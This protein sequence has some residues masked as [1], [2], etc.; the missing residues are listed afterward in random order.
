MN[1]E[2][3]TV[4]IY[5]RVSTD[6]QKKFGIS[7]DDQKNSLTRYCKENKYKIYDYYIDEGVSAGTISK[8]KEFVRLLKDLDKI[9]IILFT[10]LDRFSRN[11]RDAN[12][13]LVELDK[14]N[15][16]FKAIDEDDIDT[17]TADGRFIFNLKVNLAE[18]ERN[19]DSERI[20][21]VNKYKYHT[22]KTVCSGAKKFG[23]DIKDKR[24]VINE[25]EAIQL[26]ALY[27][28]YI[29][30][31]C[32]SETIK[33]FQLNIKKRSYASVRIYLTD[34]SYIGKYKHTFRKTKETEIIDNFCPPIID[35]EKFYKVQKMLNNNVKKYIEKKNPE[36]G[37]KADYIFSGMLFCKCGKKLS[38]KH[39]KGKHYY[40]CKRA[41]TTICDNKIHISELWL[42][43]YLL[44]NIKELINKELQKYEIANIKS[45]EKQEKKSKKERIK[46]VKNKMEKI[47]N[48][49]LEEMIDED[50]Y[51]KEY[52][53]LKEELNKIE[54]EKEENNDSE[55]D[56]E[57]LKKFLNSDFQTIYNSLSNKEKRELWLSIIEKITFNSKEDFYITLSCTKL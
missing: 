37:N 17:S 15:T 55:I 24:L 36:R 25:N 35:E 47:V 5:C 33:W 18:H 39:S 14:H 29:E 41:L 4:A 45:K 32:L 21:R 19:K 2:I 23:Y 49:Y 42:E 10:K 9:D 20:N 11:V 54:K 51:K 7:V 50:Y 44:E 34:I 8:R 57:A 46:D 30:T 43:R 27:D 38:G 1:N 31:N 52:L 28:K 12:N 3:K 26:N 53:K 48:L 56:Y 13:L 6:E 16:S 22:A 40:I